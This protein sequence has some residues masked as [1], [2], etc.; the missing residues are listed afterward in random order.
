MQ[1]L[2]S[3][4]RVSCDVVDIVNSAEQLKRANLRPDEAGDGWAVT[5]RAYSIGM[6]LI[7]LVTNMSGRTA[8]YFGATNKTLANLKKIEVG[9]LVAQAPSRVYEGIIGLPDGSGRIIEQD[10]TRTKIPPDTPPDTNP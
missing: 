8:E 5:A 10:G 1:A 7:S 6:G 9:S 4:L 2:G 3:F